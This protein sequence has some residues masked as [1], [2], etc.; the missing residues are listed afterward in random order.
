MSMGLWVSSAAAA[1]AQEGLVL[2]RMPVVAQSGLWEC[3]WVPCPVPR[4]VCATVSLEA[5]EQ[6]LGC[7]SWFR[8]HHRQ[9]PHLWKWVTVTGH[10][11][12][13]PWGVMRVENIIAGPQITCWG[14]GAH[15]LLGEADGG[16]SAW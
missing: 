4:R 6:W 16:S 7:W 1:V 10:T 15:G 11:W 14:R 12:R 5:A 13:V 3:Q 8:S 9:W 2:P